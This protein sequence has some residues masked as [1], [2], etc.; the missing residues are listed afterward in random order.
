MTSLQQKPNQL[1][2]TTMSLH[3]DETLTDAAAKN[4]SLAETLEALLDRELEARHP[5]SIDRRFQL[6]ACK[7]TTPSIASTL[8]ITSPAYS[9][10]LASFVFWISTFS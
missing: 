1:N 2:L 8:T 5:R 6:A 3:L 9:A 7:Q 4:L 10:S